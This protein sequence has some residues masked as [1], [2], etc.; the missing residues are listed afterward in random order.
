M[1]SQEDDQLWKHLQG[2]S[3]KELLGLLV[4]IMK[5]TTG[6]QRSAETPP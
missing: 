3:H 4:Q 5:K 6:D 2:K 1:A